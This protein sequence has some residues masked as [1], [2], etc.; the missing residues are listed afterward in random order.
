[1]WALQVIS[2]V[3]LPDR[4]G[5][6]TTNQIKLKYCIETLFTHTHTSKAHIAKH[7]FHVSKQPQNFI[8]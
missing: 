5:K 1:M 2:A 4:N 8:K 3:C 6:N 7:L